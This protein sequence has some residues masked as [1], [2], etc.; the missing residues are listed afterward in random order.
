MLIVLIC[1]TIDFMRKPN[2]KA[3]SAIDNLV[4]WLNEPDL[5]EEHIRAYAGYRARE[6]KADEEAEKKRA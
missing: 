3:S 2:K 1:V 5:V 4:R 6:S